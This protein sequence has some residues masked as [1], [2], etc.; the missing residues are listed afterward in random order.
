MKNPIILFDADGVLTLAEEAFSIVYARSHGLDDEPFEHFF[1]TEW[2]DYVMGK[3]DLKQSI[4]ENRQLWQW[5][6]DADSFLDYWFKTE[7]I[8]N[9]QLIELIRTLDQKGVACYLA[10][11]QEKYRAAYMKDVMFPGLFRD[12]F[13]TCE[14]G[15]TKN[16]PAFYQA[17]I[18]RLRQDRPDLTPQDII[19][20]DDGQSKVDTAASVGI[21]AQLYQ[22]V[23][24]VK[25]VLADWL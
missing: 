1:Q 10:T 5:D 13:I 3:K 6:A 15:F 20:F 14:L 16:D 21:N 23:D 24:H 25:Q 12:Y 4:T 19:F 18:E 9:D 17:I 7:D 8:R 2:R 22:G 11:E